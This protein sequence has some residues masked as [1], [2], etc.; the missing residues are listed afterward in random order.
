MSA[1]CARA[2]AANAIATRT[3]TVAALARAMSGVRAP[4]RNQSPSETCA[5]SEDVVAVAYWDSLPTK[6]HS[7]IKCWGLGE[8]TRGTTTT[9]LSD[10][11]TPKAVLTL[12]RC[13][14]NSLAASMCRQPLW[15]AL[16]TAADQPDVEPAESDSG[17]DQWTLEHLR[18]AE[19]TYPAAG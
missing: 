2:T 15:Q 6:A 11:I 10:K 5:P 13:G 16:S 8:V 12:H 1:S 4:S 19:H 18:C 9:P 3:N 17:L 7:C 14:R